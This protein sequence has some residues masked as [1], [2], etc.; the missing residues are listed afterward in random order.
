MKF[1]VDV[2]SMIL[3]HFQAW[4]LWMEGKALDIVDSSLG[5]AYPAHEVSRCIQIGL[6]YV[7]EQ[8]T[9]RPTMVEVVS[10]LGNEK[11]LPASNKPTFINRRNINYGQDSSNFVG[12]PSSI[13]DVTISMLEAC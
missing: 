4:D 7:K 13:N 3:L 1:T 12:T 10:M 9:N 8:A 5:Q 2:S 6:L 11:I